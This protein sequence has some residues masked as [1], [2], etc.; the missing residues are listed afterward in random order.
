ML[1]RILQLA[2][3]AA[4]VTAQKCPST[5]TT[6][7]A[8][9]L[10]EVADK[11][12]LSTDELLAA[13]EAITTLEVEV[14]TVLQI[15]CPPAGNKADEANAP[16][17]DDDAKDEDCAVDKFTD[18]T[19]SNINN[20]FTAVIVDNPSGDMFLNQM[21]ETSTEVGDN[22]IAVHIK[23]SVGEWL[24]WMD[25]A[26]MLK[27]E[28]IIQVSTNPDN[29]IAKDGEAP[30]S[31]NS[32]ATSPLKTA[33]SLLALL[34]LG[35]G[36][37][38]AR[39]N[40]RTIQVLMV[41]CV[42]AVTAYAVGNCIN[43]ANVEVILGKSVCY[44]YDP[45]DGTNTVTIKPCVGASF[46]GNTCSYSG[47]RGQCRRDSDCTTPQRNVKGYCPFDPAGV[48]CCYTPATAIA[49]T[50]PARTPNTCTYSGKAGTCIPG[51][52][53]GSGK[54]FSRGY[55]PNDPSGV[56]CCYSTSGGSSSSTATGSSP[57]LSSGN[58]PVYS[59]APTQSIAGNNNVMYRVTKI[60]RTHLSS[61][62]IYT[63]SP[64][65][66]DN[67]IEVTTA[68]A[69]ARMYAAAARD[70]VNI[71]IS[72]GFRTVA[73]QNYFWNCYK[74][75]SCN[76][77]N[78]AARPGTSNHGRGKALDLNT[79]CG[80]QYSS[81]PPSAC[82][83]SRVYTWLAANGASYGFKR[84]VQKEPWHWEYHGSGT[85]KSSYT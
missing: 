67:T 10:Y 53:C 59:G 41:L 85:R 83:N 36:L 46:G 11:M 15:P 62:S 18:R 14:G 27:A 9:T 76:G 7:A 75:G 68:C 48:L 51:S 45:D 25:T 38:A 79:S 22:E 17:D 61:P 55:C 3:A 2:C 82:R 32:S 74:T 52:Q 73:R 40:T 39:A 20:K 24:P 54:T 71:K 35:A 44:D 29:Q 30:M 1:L 72:S 77:G 43:E 69:F 66:K 42:L 28:D 19:F 80:K 26:I 4:L 78:L 21:T 58:C 84:S 65:S 33:S 63:A 70:G 60:S 49:P 81:R 6:L 5:Y 37:N 56:Y 16:V 47:R 31:V 64:T 12:F 23:W 57:S 34:M 13:N 8:D 50:P